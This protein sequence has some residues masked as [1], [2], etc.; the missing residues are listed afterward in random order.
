MPKISQK[1]SIISFEEIVPGKTV[2]VT[3]DGYIDAIQLV[4]VFS[5]VTPRYASSVLKRIPETQFPSSNF[6]TR[7]IKA[8]SGNAKTKLVSFNHAINLVMVL[9]GNAAKE[10]RQKFADIIQRYIAGD[11]TMVNE[12]AH[13]AMAADPVSLLAR[14]SLPAP[15][16][17]ASEDA[18]LA[19]PGE[20]SLGM[21]RS[22]KEFEELNTAAK[23]YSVVVR[24]ATVDLKSLVSERTIFLETKEKEID[25]VNKHGD[26]VFYHME[27]T[28]LRE[29]ELAEMMQT[30]LRQNEIEMQAL[31]DRKNAKELFHER[32]LIT[33]A[34]QRAKPIT[35]DPSTYTTVLK[36]FRNAQGQF[37]LKNKR[38]C[39]TLLV[40]AGNK[41]KEMYEAKYGIPPTKGKEGAYD[42]NLYPLAA[43]TLIMD[44]LR[45]LYREV[46]GGKNQQPLSFGY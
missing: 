45:A 13:N 43:E 17:P 5:C 41:A 42:V 40:K 2:F 14:E 10:Y 16:L 34:E 12:L 15:A 20:L 29:I 11:A 21:K 8:G 26:A 30:K 18:D 23:E 24:A 1:M 25:L 27:K 4:V 32:A 38:E 6:I 31:V 44:S 33:L 22:R 7:K 37:K 39:D 19:L 46:Q 3:D 28:K 9:P 36:V 35:P